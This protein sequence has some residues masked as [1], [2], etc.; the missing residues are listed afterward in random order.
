MSVRDEAE[1]AFLAAAYYEAPCICPPADPD[2]VWH[3]VAPGCIAHGLPEDK[4]KAGLDAAV[5][6]LLAEIVALAD[7]AERLYGGDTGMAE[8]ESWVH[9]GSLRSALRAAGWSKA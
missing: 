9:L 1:A 6:I 8:L 3:V 2:D 5:P 7:Q 4:V